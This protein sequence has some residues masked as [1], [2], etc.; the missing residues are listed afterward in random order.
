MLRKTLGHWWFLALI[1]ALGLGIWLVTNSAQ[2][3]GVKR[4][5]ASPQAQTPLTKQEIAA[6]LKSFVEAFTNNDAA[7]LPGLFS[8][9]CTAQEVSQLESGSQLAHQV[10]FGGRYQLTVNTD[11]FVVETKG[12]QATVPIDQPEGALS[13]TATVGD[14]PLGTMTLKGGT[15]PVENPLGPFKTPI[16][17]VREDG[18]WKVQNCGELFRH[19]DEDAPETP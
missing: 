12:D 2:C 16:E 18:V 10:M 5:D 1:A 15:G 14:Q 17:F 13:A 11:W 6:A 8:K 9:E 19:G 7:A 4:G 3:S